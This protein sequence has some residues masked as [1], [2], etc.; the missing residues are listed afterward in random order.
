MG[1]INK[2]IKGS[3]PSLL[4]TE[5]ANELINALNGLLDI[6]AIEPLRV[7]K[8]DSYK[9]TLEINEDA[10]SQDLNLET[11]SVTICENGSPVVRNIYVEPQ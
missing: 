9:I 6:N 7:V 2:V 3:A 10:L 1:Y 5:K 4:Q 11:L 8:D